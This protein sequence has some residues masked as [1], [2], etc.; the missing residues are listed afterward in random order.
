MAIIQCSHCGQTIEL[1]GVAAGSRARCISCG[2][3]IAV[4]ESLPH[5]VP[6]PQAPPRSAATAV[7]STIGIVAIVL[8]GVILLIL[9]LCG[10]QIRY[11]IFGRGGGIRWG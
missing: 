9:L 1:G 10:L 8:L 2:Q 7:L 4:T 6:P 11:Q 3:E 5:H